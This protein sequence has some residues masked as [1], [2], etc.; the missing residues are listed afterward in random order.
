LAVY[1]CSLQIYQINLLRNFKQNK[2]K[3]SFEEV[4]RE[5]QT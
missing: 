5:T 3:I 1:I 2:G 4:R